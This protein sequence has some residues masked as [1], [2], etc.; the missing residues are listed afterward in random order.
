MVGIVDPCKNIPESKMWPRT[1][2]RPEN[3][4]CLLLQR[5][6]A[7]VRSRNAGWA[8]WMC[9]AQMLEEEPWAGGAFP[10]FRI[11]MVSDG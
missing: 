2:Q 5:S 10:T 8:L 9:P 7:L 11:Q 4:K 3:S 6:C 1:K